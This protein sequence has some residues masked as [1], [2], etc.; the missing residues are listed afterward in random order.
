MAQ[1]LLELGD[2]VYYLPGAVNMALVVGTDQQAVVIDT[3][4]DK[5]SGRRVKGACD[6]LGVTL[7]AILNTHAH[8]DHYGG[9]DFLVRN[10]SVPVH[11]PPF[12]ASIIENPYLEPVYL[13]NGP[14]RP[15]NSGANG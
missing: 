15:R 13:F 10:L 4:G 9:N 2:G 7:T 8:A 6:A 3:G 11:A 14:N 12:E 1:D 5:D